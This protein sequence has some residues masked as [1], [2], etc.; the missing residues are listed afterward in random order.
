MKKLFK[1]VL[2]T[3]LAHYLASYVARPVLALALKE[4]INLQILLT[5]KF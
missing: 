1:L 5:E 4:V 3:I 2:N